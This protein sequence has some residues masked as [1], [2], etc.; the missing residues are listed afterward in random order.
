M[1]L[2]LRDWAQFDGWGSYPDA[3]QSCPVFQGIYR[4]ARRFY[5]LFQ[6]HASL[7]SAQEDNGLFGPNQSFSYLRL[8]GATVAVLGPDSR[9]ERTK[10][11]IIS[12][13]ALDLIFSKCAPLS[14]TL[15]AVHAIF[16]ST[17]ALAGRDHVAGGWA[18]ASA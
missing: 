10:Q 9:A 5:L 17:R 8:F 7:E 1:S 16:G 3:L 13:E 12:P 4:V 14:I 6:Q 2:A 18:A 15:A 11:R